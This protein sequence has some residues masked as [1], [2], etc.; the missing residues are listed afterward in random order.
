MR[1]VSLLPSATEIICEL[2]LG[3]QLVGV[4]H[5][6]DYPPFVL[7]L[8]KVTRTLIP[9]DASSRQIDAMVRER[10]R[11]QRA[12]YTLDLP[13]LEQLRPD[14]IVTQALCD[15]CAVAEEEVK[16][17]ACTLPGQPRVVNL[18][19]M[20]LE[21]VFASLRQVAEAAGVADRANIVA[22][23]LRRRVQAVA[24]RSARLDRRRRVVLLEWI[25][26]PFCCGHWTPELIRLAGGIELIGQEGQPS[27][28]ISWE[29]V[30]RADPDVLVLACCGYSVER[31]LADLP[32]LRSFPG[33][34]DLKCVQS[35]QVYVVDGSAYFSRP[36][37]R[38]VDSLEILAHLL[39]PDVHPLPAGLP[40]PCLLKQALTV[41][42]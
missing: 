27:R 33:Y 5:E 24:E 11:T 30:R 4:T 1:I 40:Q 17:A 22:N 23:A 42:P 3:G 8:P 13:V 36:G 38:L 34:G 14:L 18:E 12:L 7:S 28:T 21:E 10:L 9:A 29:A 15:V 35:G 37:P 20:R 16:Q 32:I 25:D 19:P 6:C 31:T 26:P 41:S 39:H 2:G